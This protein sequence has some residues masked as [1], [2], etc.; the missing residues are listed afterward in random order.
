VWLIH[1]QAQHQVVTSRPLQGRQLR[2]GSALQA[3]SRTGLPSPR[4]LTALPESSVPFQ[5]PTAATALGLA[6]QGL[7]AQEGVQQQHH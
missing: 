4:A 3:S 5:G 7:T 1:A 6:Q 2:A